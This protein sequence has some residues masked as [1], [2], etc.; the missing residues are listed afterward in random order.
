VAEPPPEGPPEIR[1]S[2]DDRNAVVARLHLALGEGRL[3]P[4]EFAQRADAA[5]EAVTTAE[6]EALV[7][8]LPGE[9]RAAT[10]IVGA[11]AAAAP[12]SSVFGDVKLAGRMS[13]PPQARTV[14]GDVRLDLR[15]MSTDA[16][17]L[18]LSL[19][20]V[21]GDVEVIVA[22]GV[23][24]ELYGWT[25]FGDRQIELAPVPRLAGTPLIIVHARTVFGD[26]RL[27]SLA[28]GQS[29]SRWRALLD[30]LAQWPPPPPPPPPPVPPVPPPPPAPPSR[31]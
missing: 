27:R 25:V 16:D 7:A 24:A 30:R 2:D 6:L 22:E 20:T 14:F 1:A 21:F 11:R 13:V 31:P 3:N 10:E 29:P 18:E 15:E 8:D 19:G 26:L 9:P 17:R 4:D 12:L 28:P 5:S 23:D